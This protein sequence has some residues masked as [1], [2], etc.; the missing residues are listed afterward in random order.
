M[1]VSLKH[2]GTDDGSINNISHAVVHG[3]VVDGKQARWRAQ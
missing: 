1:W 3:L 2:D